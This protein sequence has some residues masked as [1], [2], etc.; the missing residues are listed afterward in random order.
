MSGVLPVGN[1]ENGD[2]RL[3]ATLDGGATV[4]RFGMSSAQLKQKVE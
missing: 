2:S 3:Q 4:A 1:A